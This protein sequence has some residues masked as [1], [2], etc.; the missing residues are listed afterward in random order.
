MECNFCVKRGISEDKVR[1]D[2]QEIPQKEQ[3]WYVRSIINQDK[4]WATRR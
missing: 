1:L 2:P 3:F 4:D